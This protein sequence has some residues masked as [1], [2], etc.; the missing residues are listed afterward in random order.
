MHECKLLISL[1][2]MIKSTIVA[3]FEHEFNE[4]IDDDSS[5]YSKITDYRNFTYDDVAV[6]TW[7]KSILFANAFIVSGGLVY[8]VFAHSI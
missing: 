8:V 6:K 7:V 4:E 1:D 5:V 2:S 3:L